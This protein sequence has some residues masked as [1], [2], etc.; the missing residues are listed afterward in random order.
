MDPL[1]KENY[2]YAINKNKNKFQLL[3]FLENK[4]SI[5]FKTSIWEFASAIEYSNRIP[6]TRWDE[7]WIILSE[8]WTNLIPL[9]ESNIIE[10][11]SWFDISNLDIYTWAVVVINNIST[12]LEANKVVYNWY[13]WDWNWLTVKLWECWNDLTL[14]QDW[15][16]YTY[17][18]KLMSWSSIYSKCWISWETPISHKPNNYWKERTDC[19]WTNCPSWSNWDYT[20]Q[21]PESC[22]IIDC[23]KVS[24]WLYTWN[25]AM[26]WWDSE[27]E[28][29]D[30]LCNQLNT[31]PNQTWW[32]LPKRSDWTDITSEFWWNSEVL[33]NWWTNKKMGWLLNVLPWDRDPEWKFANFGEFEFWWSSTSPDIN[34]SYYYYLNTITAGENFLSK[35]HGFTV[36]CLKN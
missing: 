6:Y 4:D 26:W 19:T 18:T 22:N 5:A 32:I 2:I 12:P 14:N 9:Q 11:W 36:I 34:R 33:W 7:L 17:K 13:T 16:D 28:S 8:T 21:T 31:I 35:V 20:I 15:K 27:L 10:S 29:K 30:S 3:A 25:A 24:F 23:P 1:D